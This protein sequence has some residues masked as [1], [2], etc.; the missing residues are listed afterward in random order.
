MFAHPS[1]ITDPPSTSEFQ[2]VIELHEL[3]LILIFALSKGRTLYF[4][5]FD[6]N[7]HVRFAMSYVNES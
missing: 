4:L 6:A 2:N 5:Y 1:A 7:P 3:R